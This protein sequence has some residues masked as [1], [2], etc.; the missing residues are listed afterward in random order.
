MLCTQ[1][2]L[3]PELRRVNVRATNDAVWL[4]ICT[5][6]TLS[7]DPAP[8]GLAR[9]RNATTPATTSTP[10]SAIS[11]TLTGGRLRLAVPNSSPMWMVGPR[12]ATGGVLAAGP[13][14][15]AEGTETG[16]GV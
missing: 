4:G 7:S 15:V 8:C 2:G 12:R 3:S 9:W 1:S 16:L 11:K 10:A 5:A 13:V 6:V 14:G